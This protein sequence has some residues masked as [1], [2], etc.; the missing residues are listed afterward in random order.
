MSNRSY[1]HISPKITFVPYLHSTQRNIIKKLLNLNYPNQLDKYIE[2]LTD[3]KPFIAYIDLMTYDQRVVVTNKLCE[4]FHFLEEGTLSYIDGE[5]FRTFT[6]ID[7]K[8]GF[9]VNYLNEFW[10]IKEGISRILRGYTFRLVSLPQN[11][12]AYSSFYNVK[13]HTFSEYGYPNVI[14]SKKVVLGLKVLNKCDLIEKQFIGYKDIAIW[15]EDSIHMAFGY[16]REDYLK[17]IIEFINNYGHLL[18]GKTLYIKDRPSSH[19]PIHDISNLFE[20]YGLKVELIDKDEILELALINSDN[21]TVFG[22]VSSLLFYAGLLGHTCYSIAD[23]YPKQ[24]L[25]EYDNNING[26][27]DVV[28]RLSF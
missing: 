4:G 23:L 11:P 16:P 26:F 10:K 18:N 21:V 6:S 14:N 15:I 2:S 19:R 7:M 12:S 5:N 24:L 28:H 22:G 20:N 13:F 27:F 17:S 25:M 9:R 3:S 1:S 8:F